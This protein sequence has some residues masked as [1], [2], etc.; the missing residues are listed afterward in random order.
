MKLLAFL[1]AVF[2]YA[3]PSSAADIVFHGKPIKKVTSTFEDTKAEALSDQASTEFA[4]TVIS[5]G[6]KF[7]LA[8]R[9]NKPLNKSE[10]GSY[11]T[12]HAI[13]G[14]GYVS[15]ATNVPVWYCGAPA[16]ACRHSRATRLAIENRAL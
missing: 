4:V 12:F 3:A 16:R 2:A 7:F 8:S 1:I 14:S 11:I 9:E 5:E 15:E 13:D 6:G 10:S